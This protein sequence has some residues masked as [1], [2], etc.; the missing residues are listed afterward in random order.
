MHV[1]VGE[2]NQAIVECVCVFVIINNRPAGVGMVPGI[3]PSATI[4]SDTLGRVWGTEEKMYSASVCFCICE[5]VECV[6]V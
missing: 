3:K 4:S 5:C 1:A 2:T 6:S